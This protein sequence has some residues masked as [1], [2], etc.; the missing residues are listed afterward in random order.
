MGQL[1]AEMEAAG[2]LINTGGLAP[3]GTSLRV[4]RANGS[5]TVTD[6]PFTETKELI[7]GYAVL[8]VQSRDE[9]IAWSK[10]FLDIAGNG[11]SEVYEL[12]EIA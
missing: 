11:V 2:V 6:G 10:R 9:L 5:V 12:A 7:G 3:T 4:R 8:N 1:I